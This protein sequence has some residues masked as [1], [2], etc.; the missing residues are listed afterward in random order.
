MASLYLLGHKDH[1]TSH[2]F[3]HVYWKNFVKHVQ[4]AWIDKDENDMDVDTDKV[5]LWNQEGKVIGRC[6][7]SRWTCFRRER[8]MVGWIWLELLTNA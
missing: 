6:S 7:R 2:K 4:N 3:V 5:I 8:W 1:Y